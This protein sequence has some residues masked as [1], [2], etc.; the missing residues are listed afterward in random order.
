MDLP[1]RLVW[2][3]E[4]RR[5]AAERGWLGETERERELERQRAESED[6]QRAQHEDESE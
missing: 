5:G 4:G 1:T 2:E 3:T 6:D